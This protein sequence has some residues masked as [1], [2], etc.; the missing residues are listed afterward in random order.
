MSKAAKT[1]NVQHPKS[2]REEM[3]WALV[4]WLH[5]YFGDEIKDCELVAEWGSA[6]IKDAGQRSRYPNK[7]SR[8]RA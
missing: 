8:A 3:R 5:G 4:A 6:E 2:N 1:S 7:L